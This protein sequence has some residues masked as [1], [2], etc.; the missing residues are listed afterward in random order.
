MELLDKINDWHTEFIARMKDVS[1]GLGRREVRDAARSYVQGLMMSLPSKHCWAIAEA[2]GAS[3]PQSHQRLLRSARWHETTLARRRCR[4]IVDEMGADDGVL[5]LD[6]TGFLKS[7]SHSVGVQRQYSGT[8][9]KRENCQIAVFSAYASSKGRTLVDTRLYLP[10]SWS[11]A[12]ERRTQA[13]VPEEIEFQTKPQLA[14]E[15]VDQSL[16]DE[17]P[18]E[19]VTADSVYGSN[20]ELRQHLIDRE[21]TFVMAVESNTHVYSRR[22]R[23]LYRSPPASRRGRPPIRPHIPTPS[24]RVDTIVDAWSPNT[25]QRLRVGAG[26]KGPRVYDWAARRVAA[27]KK[28]EGI[29][30][31]WLM[32]RRS[33]S[34]PSEMAYYLAWAPAQTSL[35]TLA[36]VASRRWPI[37]S[38]FREAKHDLGLDDYQVRKW[39]AWHR[40]MQLAMLAHLMVTLSRCV[41]DAIVDWGRVTLAEARRLWLLVMETSRRSLEDRW[42]WII[43][44]GTHNER[45]RRSHY[46]Q[47]TGRSFKPT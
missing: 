44:R 37:E 15:L 1:A 9:G 47:R 8:A 30:D 36:S 4:M 46:K 5:I 10:A 26:S 39:R 42:A 32:A 35:Q 33:V 34:R 41:F 45:A 43:W 31:L 40:H 20:F 21:L 24:R 27:Y 2:T 28:D 22:P 16:E 3:N 29:Q 11:D 25:W 12:P 23:I 6:E 38:C 17:L 19:W 18:I 14:A 7:G 13:G